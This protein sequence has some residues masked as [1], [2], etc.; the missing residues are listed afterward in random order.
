MA[1]KTSIKLISAPSELIGSIDLPISKSLSNRALVLEFLA[2]E[3]INTLE[4]SSANDSQLLKRILSEGLKANE[5]NVED[6]GTVARFTLAICAVLDNKTRL[7]KGT[8]R[9]HRRPMKPLT[10][11]LIQ[12]GADIDFLDKDGF[13]PL[14]I[15]GTKNPKSNCTLN[16]S[17]SSQFLTALLLI[18][19]KLPNNFKI[20]LSSEITSRPYA[21]MTFELLKQYG[22]KVIESGKQ[23]K[24]Q[25]SKFKIQNLKYLIEGDWSA[26][27]YF[28]FF[29]ALTQEIKTPSTQPTKGFLNTNSKFK[30]K[31]LKFISLQGDRYIDSILVQLGIEIT[32]DDAGVSSRIVSTQKEKIVLD[33]SKNPDLAQPFACYMV[34]QKLKGKLTGLHTLKHKETDRIEA[35]KKE[36]T[37]VGAIIET[38]DST[39]E[40]L[41]YSI[42]NSS[43]LKQVLESKIQN[44]KFNTYNDHRMAMSLALVQMAHPEFEIEHPEV[45]SKSFP[46]FW[47]TLE[48]LGF[49]YKLTE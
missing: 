7:I 48:S 38:S 35:L 3:D 47:H 17:L 15:K 14:K 5:I 18:A 33:F 40:I 37:K 28:L 13:L 32:F 11:A 26:A 44:S 25:N 39:L 27:I 24:I 36:L 29:N 16:P 45:V 46:E 10:D 19:P 2:G 41:R 20:E 6:A 43:G 34:A 8:E 42:S 23:L 9:M 4:I 49:Q 1:S 22:F 31:N 30:I 12:L 21:Q